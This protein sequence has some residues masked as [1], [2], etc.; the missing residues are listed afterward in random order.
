MTRFHKSDAENDAKMRCRRRKHA[1]FDASPRRIFAPSRAMRRRAC[2]H[3]GPGTRHTL[4]PR[5]Q[6][7]QPTR[8]AC[9]KLTATGVSLSIPPCQFRLDSCRRDW[10]RFAIFS[11]T[12]GALGS[13][14]TLGRPSS[15]A[16]GRVGAQ[17]YLPRAKAHGWIPPGSVLHDTS[18]SPGERPWLT[19]ATGQG[20]QPVPGAASLASHRN[21]INRSRRGK[22]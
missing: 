20:R 3:Q 12:S 18:H 19:G 17:Q 10:V 9:A 7:R 11:S 21:F 14:S 1:S 5:Q 4:Q 2:G 15:C 6:E 22:A 13:T 8:A 16:D